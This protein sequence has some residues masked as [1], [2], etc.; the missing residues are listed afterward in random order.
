MKDLNI[1]LLTPLNLKSYAHRFGFPE[2]NKEQVYEEPNS[3]SRYR[4]NAFIFHISLDNHIN[5]RF[6]LVYR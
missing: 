2:V 6:G 3:Y 5:Y 1:N 4:N